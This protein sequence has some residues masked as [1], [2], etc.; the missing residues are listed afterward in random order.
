[1][2]VYNIAGTVSFAQAER[3]MISVFVAHSHQ[4]S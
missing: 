4:L 2:I 3:V 1:M